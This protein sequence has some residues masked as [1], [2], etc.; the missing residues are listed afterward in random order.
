M[1]SHSKRSV[2]WHPIIPTGGI[3]FSKHYCHTPETILNVSGTA[4]NGSQATKKLI[5][6]ISKEAMELVHLETR[7]TFHVP[8]TCFWFTQ[9]SVLKYCITDYNYSHFLPILPVSHMLKDCSALTLVMLLWLT[10]CPGNLCVCWQHPWLCWLE[11]LTSP[12]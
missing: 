11:P 4:E 5:T 2:I 3:P 12:S 9:D 10:L 6:R 1:T 7:E 8:P